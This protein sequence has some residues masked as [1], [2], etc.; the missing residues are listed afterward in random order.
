M[1]RAWPGPARDFWIQDCSAATE[2][3]LLA[4]TGLGLGAV[5]IGLYPIKPLTRIVA[6]I[7]SI[8]EHI[9]PFCVIHV[10]HPTKAKDP[11]TKYNPRKVW[12]QGYGERQAEQ[13]VED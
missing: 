9:V 1:R 11:R 3:I 12:W 2:N 7:L 4:A 10:G 6:T 8:P 13:M 5:W